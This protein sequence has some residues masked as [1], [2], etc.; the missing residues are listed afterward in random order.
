MEEALKKGLKKF[1]INSEKFC[2]E[3]ADGIIHKGAPDELKFL[4]GRIF[5]KINFAPLQ[6]TF[7]P[8]CSK[9]FMIPFNKRSQFHR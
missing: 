4:E 1:E 6:L 7:H 8:Y 5:E 3:K 9:E 2:F